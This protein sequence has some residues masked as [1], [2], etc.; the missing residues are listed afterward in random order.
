MAPKVGHGL[1]CM[2]TIWTK[3][4]F[5]ACFGKEAVCWHKSAAYTDG[6]ITHG[7][8][9]SR[10]RTIDVMGPPSLDLLVDDKGC[11]RSSS[12]PSVIWC[13]PAAAILPLSQAASG[14]RSRPNLPQTIFIKYKDINHSKPPHSIC[15]NQTPLHLDLLVGWVEMDILCKT[16]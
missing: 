10:S 13:R 3:W 5:L 12:T 2:D 9:P 4:H 14:P 8:C 7:S 16:V 1:P 6:L 11:A 15:E